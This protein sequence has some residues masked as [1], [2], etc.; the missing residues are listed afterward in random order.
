[1]TPCP[2]IPGERQKNPFREREL[3][4]MEFFILQEIPTNFLQNEK[5][6]G[7]AQNVRGTFV[8]R[9][10]KWNEEHTSA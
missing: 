2:E 1:M 10:P 9:R 8:L 6:P 5:L 3:R 7:G 4:D